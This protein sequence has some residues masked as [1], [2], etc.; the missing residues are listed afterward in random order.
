M[1]NIR[2]IRKRKKITQQQLADTMNVSQS[3]VCSWEN[4]V[5]HPRTAD[6]PRLAAVLDVTVDELLR[7]PDAAPERK[8]A[9]T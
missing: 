1:N 6:L 9:S 2:E 8:E 5:S 3:S 7:E 4:G